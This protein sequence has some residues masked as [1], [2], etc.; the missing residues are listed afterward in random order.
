MSEDVVAPSDE[1]K[2]DALVEKASNTTGG[3]TNTRV[4]QR[5]WICDK[6][7]VKWFL[8]FNEAC[9]HE[10]NCVVLQDALRVASVAVCSFLDIDSI[11]NASCVSKELLGLL[12]RRDG[13]LLQYLGLLVNDIGI[14]DPNPN[15]PNMDYFTTE[16][17]SE[18][19]QL[20]RYLWKV[21]RCT[22]VFY[23]IPTTLV[24]H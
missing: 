8:D 11:I 23:H 4:L 22:L 6:C 19:I 7:K 1:K 10:K 9:E 17:S 16:G 24:H 5:R 20:A 14:K 18:N 21:S 2:E 12:G 3:N 13:P 15:S